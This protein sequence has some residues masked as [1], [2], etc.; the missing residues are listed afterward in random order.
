MGDTRK[1]LNI[2]IHRVANGFTVDV[3]WEEGVGKDNEYKS[4][5]FIFT[6]RAEALKKVDEALG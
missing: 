1:D 6:D 2:S 3:N 4:E 5:E